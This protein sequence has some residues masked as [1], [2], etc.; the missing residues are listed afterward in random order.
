[1]KASTNDTPAWVQAV[2]ACPRCKTSLKFAG[3]QGCHCENC[4]HI[5]A[6]G[7]S[8]QPDLRMHEPLEVAL[9]TRYDPSLTVIPESLWVL[10]GE[11]EK[12]L[13]QARTI[14]DRPEA[15]I[16][17]WMIH[18]IKPGDLVLD[19][20]AKSNRD[21]K[22]V[23]DLGAR[24]LAVEIAAPDAM[25]LGDAHALPL[26]NESVDVVLCMN[27][28]EHL[29]NPFLAA[30]EIKRV[31]KPNGRFI[32]IVG[33]IEAVHGLPHGSYFHHSYLGVHTVL[34]ASGF[35]VD[36][37]GVSPGWQAIHSISRAML[38]GLPKKVA[39]AM[40]KPVQKLQNLLWYMYG[41]K[42][43]NTAKVFRERDRLL[44]AG[45]QFAA[46]SIKADS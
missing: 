35:R 14:T 24:Y 45:V 42:K 32:G 26:R 1:M 20:G 2:I 9:P 27:V 30:H 13:Q 22:I 23:E 40:V 29:K 39:Y 31:L 5:F 6:P 41:I 7:P 37:L 3:E 8:G 25:V 10:P 11:V 21:M 12:K 44:A 46:T 19:I 15:S 18:S 43:G 38:P 34:T 17:G 16:K 28:F 4:N 36:Y 33:F